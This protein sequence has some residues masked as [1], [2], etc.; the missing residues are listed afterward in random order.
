MHAI[1]RYILAPA[2]IAAATFVAVPAVHLAASPAAH[3]R[4]SIADQVCPRGTNWDN[5]LQLCI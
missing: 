5:V 3:S 1:K 4:T 2:V